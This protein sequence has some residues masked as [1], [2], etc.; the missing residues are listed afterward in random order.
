[1]CLLGS[2]NLQTPAQSLSL[3]WHLPPGPTPRH[4]L[5]QSHPPITPPKVSVLPSGSRPQAG[6]GNP[7]PCP[8]C[9]G[10]AWGGMLWPPLHN[11][12]RPWAFSP[13]GR[14]LQALAPHPGVTKYYV[15]LTRWGERPSVGP[16][17]LN[18]GQ[19]TPL[20]GPLLCPSAPGA[21]DDGSWRCPPPPARRLRDR[22]CTEAGLGL[23]A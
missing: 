4:H 6:D 8:A 14:P 9:G 16:V 18:S 2:S 22:L 7:L 23:P 15:L 10:P 5:N 11:R 19:M 21:E 1:M 17:C 20:S 3:S 13:P 12:T